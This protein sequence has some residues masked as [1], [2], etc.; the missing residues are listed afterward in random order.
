MI[1]YLNELK[2]AFPVCQK[3]YTTGIPFYGDELFRPDYG[4]GTGRRL[5]QFVI[6]PIEADVPPGQPLPLK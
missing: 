4:N 3:V 2:D 1:W 6:N 5:F